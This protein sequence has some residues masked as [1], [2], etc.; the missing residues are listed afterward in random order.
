MANNVRGVG[1][2]HQF[3]KSVKSDVVYH[4]YFIAFF[5]HKALPPQMILLLRNMVMAVFLFPMRQGVLCNVNV[6]T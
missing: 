3:S 6:T 4:N 2:D 1:N 5:M